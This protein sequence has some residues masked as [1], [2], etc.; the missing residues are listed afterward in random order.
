MW[1]AD[2]VQIGKWITLPTGQRDPN[3]ESAKSWHQ[4]AEITQIWLLYG[5]WKIPNNLKHKSNVYF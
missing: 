2:V 1:S 4:Y 5:A 3:K